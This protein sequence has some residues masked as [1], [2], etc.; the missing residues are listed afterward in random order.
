MPSDRL[1]DRVLFVANAMQRIVLL[2]GSFV[3]DDRSE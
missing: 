1:F 2:H 3:D